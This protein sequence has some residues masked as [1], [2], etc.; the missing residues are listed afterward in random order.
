MQTSD[1]I[2]NLTEYSKYGSAYKAGRIPHVVLVAHHTMTSDD[3][4]T[5]LHEFFHSNHNSIA[6]DVVILCS[7]G[8]EHRKKLLYHVKSTRFWAQ[9]S[10]IVGSPSSVSDLQK[11]AVQRAQACF[12][13]TSARFLDPEQ[14]LAADEETLLRA[15]SIKHYCPQVPLIMHILSPRNKA[16]VLWFQ[17]SK[18]P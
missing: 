4:D 17:L 14:E 15:V 16:H 10:Y 9:V 18:F 13:I 6:Y 5:L 1:F 3:L 7:G 12:L 2:S 11:A 8:D